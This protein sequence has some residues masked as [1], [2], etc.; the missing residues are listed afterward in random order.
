MLA[1][2]PSGTSLFRSEAVQFQIERRQ[3]GEI[4]DLH[5]VSSRMMSWGA[6]ATVA[7]IIA[8]LGVAEYARKE[9][10]SGYLR[11]SLGTAKIYVPQQGVINEVHVAQGAHVEKGQRLLTVETA[12]VATG[13]QDVNAITVSTLVK[14]RESIAGQIQEEER[15]TVLEA[16]RLGDLINSQTDAIGHVEVQIGL[17]QARIKLLRD[18]LNAAT[19]LNAKG[20]LADAE[21]KRR[22]QDALDQEQGLSEL[23]QQLA[24]LRSARNE[25]ASTQEQLPIVRGDKIQSLRND[26]AWVDQRLAETE[27]RR[28]YVVLAPATG[29]VA[30]LQATPG[31]VAAPQHLQMAIVPDGS[32]LQAELLVPTRA[33]GFIEPGQTVR[34]LYQAFPYQKYGTHSGHVVQIARSVV[35]GAEFSGP[36]AVSEPVYK[37]EVAIDRSAI[38]VDGRNVALEPDML[39]RADIVLDRRPILM[40][41]FEPLLGTRNV[42]YFDNAA[43]QLRAWL[44]APLVAAAQSVWNVLPSRVAI[45]GENARLKSCWTRALSHWTDSEHSPAE[46]GAH[47]APERVRTADQHS[48]ERK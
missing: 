46:A 38:P 3:W 20:Y 2:K 16:G 42:L 41:L 43:N 44:V 45:M 48:R 13:G 47:G 19:Q 18:V 25:T 27:G 4:I 11:P 39:L 23:N 32:V 1:V 9:S 5:P 8:F 35:T 34:L 29:T 36:I 21:Y 40:W 12:Q 17:K 28:A 22:Q 31:Q 24:S 15:R 10:V 7:L 33:A 30:M 26:L 6:V 37:V 14:Q